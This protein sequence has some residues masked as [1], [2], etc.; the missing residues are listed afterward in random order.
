MST[1]TDRFLQALQNGQE[2]TPAQIQSRFGFSSESVG[3]TVS[4]LR[5]RGYSIYTN[6]YANGVTKYRIGTPSRAIVAA[7][8][9]VLGAEALA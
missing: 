2:L 5:S 3:K 6:K 1:K 4:Q 7:G 9:S 8:Y